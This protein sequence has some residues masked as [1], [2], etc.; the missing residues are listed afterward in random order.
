[1]SHQFIQAIRSIRLFQ[2][3]QVLMSQDGIAVRNPRVIHSLL[4]NKILQKVCKLYPLSL[5]TMVKD[6]VI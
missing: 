6:K 2:P 4:L 3:L 1:M 5:S